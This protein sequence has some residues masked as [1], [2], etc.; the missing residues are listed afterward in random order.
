MMAMALHLALAVNGIGE[1]AR[2]ELSRAEPATNRAKKKTLSFSSSLTADGGNGTS[3]GI[4]GQWYRRPALF[5]F[6]R[7]GTRTERP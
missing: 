4:G 2:A 1:L 6:H 5:Q 3:L 7:Q